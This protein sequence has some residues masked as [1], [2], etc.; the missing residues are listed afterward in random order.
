[1]LQIR[2]AQLHGM[3]VYECRQVWRGKLMVALIAGFALTIG[4]DALLT[5]GNLRCDPEGQVDFV[6]CQQALMMTVTAV[7]LF[8]ALPISVLLPIMVA[9]VIPMDSQRG[10]RS[11]LDAMP[12]DN[13]T[14]L[15]G[16]LLGTWLALAAAALIAMLITGAIWWLATGT[17]F[18]VPYVGIW[19]FGI[20][21]VILL[22]GGLGVL[23]PAGFATRRNAILWNTVWII[24]LAGFLQGDD[25]RFYLNPLRLPVINYHIAAYVPF[26]E[27]TMG[28]G[29]LASLLKSFAGGLLELTIA[30][31]TAWVW[32][33]WKSS[34]T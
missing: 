15:L 7:T 27:D 34:R 31:F 4:I 24:V 3:A 20:G 16:K 12:L 19:L 14:Y 25:Y 26:Y 11:W 13:A 22:D 1:M 30:Y 23:L 32:L 8:M 6:V 21:A 29:E 5:G 9:E 18:V 10:V 33:R 28:L 2:L 17:L